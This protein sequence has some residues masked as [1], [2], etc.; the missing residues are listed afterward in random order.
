MGPLFYEQI[1]LKSP[2]THTLVQYRFRPVQPIF[3]SSKPQ[4]HPVNSK[5]ILLGQDS[6]KCGET[7][8]PPTPP[9]LS[10]DQSIP[11]KGGERCGACSPPPRPETQP[12]TEEET[13][14]TDG[15]LCVSPSLLYIYISTL[16]VIS[17]FSRYNIN[18]I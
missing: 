13:L 2:F 7:G 4:V 5:S 8:P 17:S 10:I 12:A 1:Y 18:H 15:F 9:N 14:S 6:Q 3:T 11:R 16:T